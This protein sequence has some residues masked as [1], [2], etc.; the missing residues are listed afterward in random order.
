MIEFDNS[1]NT[2]L[3]FQFDTNNKKETLVKYIQSI[4]KN[5]Y[6]LLIDKGIN[7]KDIDIKLNSKKFYLVVGRGNKYIKTLKLDA[8]TTY[9]VNDIYELIRN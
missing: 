5:K 2:V 1:L 3:K 8:E 7:I 4:N 6:F 9:R